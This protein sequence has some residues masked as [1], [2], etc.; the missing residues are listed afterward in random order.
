MTTMISSR[1]PEGSPHRCPVCG[2]YA[3]LEP[4]YPG[5]DSVCPS[6]GQLLWWF[7]DQ[8]G[9]HVRLNSA[10]RADLVRLDSALK[11]ELG[12]DSIAVVEWIMELEEE[13]DVVLPD[14]FLD[15]VETIED[16]IRLIRRLQGGEAA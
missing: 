12:A 7:R 15:R 14:D 5:G 8:I 13:F 3:A 10:L 9:D 4:C 6:C 16:L 1:T 11:S 2:N